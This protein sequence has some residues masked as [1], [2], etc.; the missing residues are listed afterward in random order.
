MVIAR[1]LGWVD[2]ALIVLVVLGVAIPEVGLRPMP[3]TR[4]GSVAAIDGPRAAQ[5]ALGTIRALPGRYV[6]DPRHAGIV[7]GIVLGRTDE[8]SNADKLLFKRSGL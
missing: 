4:R 3:D 2:A 6:R 8:I 5:P 1:K 7:A